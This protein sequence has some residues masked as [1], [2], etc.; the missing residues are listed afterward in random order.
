M[1]ERRAMLKG[2]ACADVSGCLEPNLAADLAS[3]LNLFKL[4]FSQQTHTLAQFSLTS[5]LPTRTQA[6]SVTN[7]HS[8]THTFCRGSNSSPFIDF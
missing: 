2:E 6:Q 5:V 4:P 3:K 7:T 1:M 8:H